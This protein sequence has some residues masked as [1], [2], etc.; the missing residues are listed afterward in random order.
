MSI[1]GVRRLADERRSHRGG[2][3]TGGVFVGE[4][5]ANGGGDV[6]ASRCGHRRGER[7]RRRKGIIP[8]VTRGSGGGGGGRREA[9]PGRTAGAKAAEGRWDWDLGMVGTGLG[10]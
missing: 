5:E 7:R 1:G 9:A 2:G 3:S 6:K 8:H 10:I 4:G